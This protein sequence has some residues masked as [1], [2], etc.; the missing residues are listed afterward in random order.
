[1]KTN[2]SGWGVGFRGLGA[3]MDCQ[4]SREKALRNLC[5]LAPLGI[6]VIKS[7][8]NRRETERAINANFDYVVND[9]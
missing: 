8:I 2:T 5:M 4:K 9:Q 3:W 6:N 1:M 7:V